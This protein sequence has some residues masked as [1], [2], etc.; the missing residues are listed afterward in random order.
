MRA[1]C[2][3]EGTGHGGL[4]G[5]TSKLDYLHALGVDCIWL[6]PIY[7]SPLKVVSMRV[8]AILTTTG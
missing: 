5:I 6:L 2:D 1:F 3:L 7:P 4:T 8:N